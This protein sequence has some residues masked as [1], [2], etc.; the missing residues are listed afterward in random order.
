MAQPK[1]WKEAKHAVLQEWDA[2]SKPNSDDDRS[3]RFFEYLQTARP[4]LLKFNYPGDRWMIVQAW[5]IN[6]G[7]LDG[8]NSTPTNRRLVQVSV[9]KSGHR[10][11]QHS[12]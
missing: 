12:A 10:S 6:T 3:L 2:W 5:L 11:R 1:L 8:P 9:G 7:R 4:D